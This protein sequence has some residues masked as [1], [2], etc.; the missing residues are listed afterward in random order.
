MPMT[1]GKPRTPYQRRQ[2][3]R[4]KRAWKK[5]LNDR[6]QLKELAMA[7]QLENFLQLKVGPDKPRRTGVVACERL[8]PSPSSSSATVDESQIETQM[9][10]ESSTGDKRIIVYAPQTPPKKKSLTRQRDDDEVTCIPETPPSSPTELLTNAGE[11]AVGTSLSTFCTRQNNDRVTDVSRVNVHVLNTQP[12]HPDFN[13][14]ASDG[15]MPMPDTND[16]LSGTSCLKSIL[17]TKRVHFQNDGQS[18]LTSESDDNSSEYDVCDEDEASQVFLSSR[19]GRSTVVDRSSGDDDSSEPESFDNG[20]DH[21]RLLPDTPDRLRLNLESLDL[22]S[23]GEADIAINYTV[24]E[25][26]GEPMVEGPPDPDPG[27]S[28]SSSDSDSS[29]DAGDPVGRPQH[30][31][32]DDDDPDND[33]SEHG[34]D[35]D[36]DDDDPLP[37]RVPADIHEGPEMNRHEDYLLEMLAD[38]LAALRAGTQIGHFAAERIYQFMVEYKGVM[39]LITNFPKSYKT[40]R[41]KS[42]KK[43]P[44]I[45]IKMMIQNLETEEV[46]E[47]QGDK[48]ERAVYGNPMQFRVLET[49]TSITLADALSWHDKWHN[50]YTNEDEGEQPQWRDSEQEPVEIDMSWDGIEADRKKDKVLEVLSMRRAD[51]NRVIALSK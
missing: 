32:P 28:S 39:Q 38:G 25:P 2:V 42:D 19:H 45:E 34:D 18:L 49:W 50:R 14:S 12:F 6:K 35:S 33:G 21:Y 15:V 46:F 37:D 36:P 24:E 40:M 44:P 17:K 26:P 43:L 27:D 4:A 7:R 16:V 20:E 5:K 48:F 13:N 22:S 41:R 10:Y 31:E 23:D 3:T 1:F 29:S 47:V 9:L 8:E 11:S 30:G 51:C